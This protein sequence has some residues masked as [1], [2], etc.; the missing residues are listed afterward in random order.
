MQRLHSGHQGGRQ[1]RVSV[2]CTD[3]SVFLQIPNKKLTPEQVDEFKAEIYIMSK[4]FNPRIALFMGAFIPDDDEKNMAIVSEVLHGD[5][6][7]LLRGVCARV[8]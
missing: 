7:E 1:A 8:C 6:S 5:I 4:L 2:P 3:S